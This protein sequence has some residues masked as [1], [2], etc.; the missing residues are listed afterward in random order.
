M[1]CLKTAGWVAN[2]VD[3]D[4]TP[5]SAASHL[6]LYCLLRPVCLN[7]YGKYGKPW[8][9]TKTRFCISTLLAT[10]LCLYTQYSIISRIC[11]WYWTKTFDMQAFLGTAQD[12][13]LTLKVPSKICSRRQLFLFFLI[14]QRKQVLIFHVN[15][16]LLGRRFTWNIKT[17]F[18]WKIKKK[19][20][21]MSSAAV[22]IGALR[23]KSDEIF[24]DTV[25][26]L[27]IG[28]SVGNRTGKSQSIIGKVKLIDYR[29]YNRI[30]HNW[31]QIINRY[32]IC[33]IFLVNESFTI[34]L[35][36][37]SHYVTFGPCF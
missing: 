29:L 15:R 33:T 12:K 1:L 4:E 19:Y 9:K 30:S 24:F 18:L 13:V 10:F 25:F 26:T 35:I 20:S 32:S 31:C 5:R 17:C 14:F 36:C 8:V 7:T 28:T 11:L 37:R 2:S 22:M 34:L 6:G 16:L 27:N 21:K 3:P 23:V